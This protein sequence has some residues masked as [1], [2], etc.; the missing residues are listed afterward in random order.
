VVQGI[1]TN[2]HTGVK[3]VFNRVLIKTEILPVPFGILY[4]KLFNLRQDADYR[5][6]R[7]HAEDEVIPLIEEVADFV[8][9]MKRLMDV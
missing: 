1:D 8:L 4:N 5:D 3:A 2:T 6:Y 9:R 7:D